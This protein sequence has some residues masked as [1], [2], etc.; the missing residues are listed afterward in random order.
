MKDVLVMEWER[1]KNQEEGWEKQEDTGR[2]G[3]ASS[4][5]A[6]G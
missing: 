3:R 2:G 6:T 4:G 1:K 5:A